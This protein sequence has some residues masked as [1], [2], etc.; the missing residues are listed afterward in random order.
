MLRGTASLNCCFLAVAV[1]VPQK[2]DTLSGVMFVTYYVVVEIF[3]AMVMLFCLR[4]RPPPLVRFRNQPINTGDSDLVLGM[5]ISLDPME[6]ELG[7]ARDMNDGDGPAGARV[8]GVST[9]SIPVTAG[10]RMNGY[11]SGS[12]GDNG[13]ARK[14]AVTGAVSVV[15]AATPNT[16]GW[17]KTR[18]AALASPYT[19]GL[20]VGTRLSE[21]PTPAT[22]YVSADFGTP[23]RP[24]QRNRSMDSASQSQSEASSRRDT[25]R[26]KPKR[27]PGKG[28]GR[29][30][31][32]DGGPGAQHDDE[33]E[34]VPTEDT[35]PLPNGGL[36]SASDVTPLL[37]RRSHA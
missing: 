35:V 16:P 37:S 3:P 5:N 4:R 27:S 31:V 23:T 25:R 28:L 1:S 33:E 11:S 2:F 7:A 10:L 32:S 22:E 12:L 13:S 14:Q 30:Y 36:E 24:S 34:F 6:G 21:Y 17:P 8:N 20:R 18:A 26:H 29:V 19:P 9:N 15:P